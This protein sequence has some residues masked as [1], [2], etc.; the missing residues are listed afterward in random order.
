MNLSG[1]VSIPPPVGDPV[2][3]ELDVPGV[4][5]L[6][7]GTF[8]RTEHGMFAYGMFTPGVCHLDVAPVVRQGW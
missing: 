6:R 8:T 4:G 5:R 2:T 7:P 3:G 1:H